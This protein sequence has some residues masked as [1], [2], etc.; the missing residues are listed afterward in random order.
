M[1]YFIYGF[2]LLVLWKWISRRDIVNFWIHLVIIEANVAKEYCSAMHRH[3]WIRCILNKAFGLPRIWHNCQQ[4]Q[5]QKYQRQ[6]QQWQYKKRRR[7]RRRKSNNIGCNVLSE[8]EDRNRKRRDETIRGISSLQRAHFIRTISLRK[9]PLQIT[10]YAPAHS[11][12]SL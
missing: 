7:K 12:G 8:H 2:D 3:K 6:Q 4:L 11:D 9:K 10:A 5:Q 1:S